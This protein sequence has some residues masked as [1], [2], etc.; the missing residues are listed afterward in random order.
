MQNLRNLRILEQNCKNPDFLDFLT[1]ACKILPPHMHQIHETVSFL[2]R[3][4]S[5][6]LLGKKESLFDS[7]P[8]HVIT[9]IAK[10]TVFFPKT[11]PLKMELSI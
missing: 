4:V 3:S 1:F 2:E 9:K 8:K 6:S 11:D 5:K 10:I 7:N